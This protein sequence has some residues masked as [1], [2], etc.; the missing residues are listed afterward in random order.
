VT[1]SSGGCGRTTENV[2]IAPGIEAGDLELGIPRENPDREAVHEEAH[3][4][5]REINR[6]LSQGL[7]MQFRNKLT[8]SIADVQYFLL[9]F[10]KIPLGKLFTTIRI[11][12][13]ISITERICR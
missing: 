10:T 7:I 8:R 3:T 6:H 2:R 12:W 5:F 11:Y 9:S 4:A 13:E 1:G